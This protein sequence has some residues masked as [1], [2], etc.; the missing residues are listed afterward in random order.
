MAG[1]HVAGLV[2]LIISANPGL[3]GDVD[4]IEDIIEQT[5]VHLTT[6]DG[7]GGDGPADSPN[8]TFGWGRFDALAAV[9]AA[10]AV[11]P[12]VD[13]RVFLEGSYSGGQMTP[14]LSGDLPT[15]QP[16][17]GAP[18]NY[19]GTESVDASFF[20]A[21]PDIIDWVLVELRAD[22]A[23]TLA[24]RA[25][26]VRNDGAVV[27]LDGTSPVLFAEA[28]AGQPL[29][30]AVFHRNHLAAMS[31]AALAPSGDVYGHDFT[32]GAAF[33]FDP[34]KNFGDGNFGLYAGDADADGQVQTD[35]KNVQWRQQIGLSGYQSADF[36]LNSQVQNDDKNFYWRPNVGKGSAI[37]Q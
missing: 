33:G 8:N 25:A 28:S 4:A 10:L 7:C 31:P 27:D 32:G 34:L 29:F 3:A 24:R 21:H 19:A 36:N 30:V 37:D 18:W 1:P 20:A 14:A 11:A 15:D 13:A 35:D 22:A 17:S 26:F 23:T 2:A 6:N 5:A 9:Q 16:Y 12:T